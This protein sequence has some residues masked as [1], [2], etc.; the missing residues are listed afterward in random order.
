MWNLILP[1]TSS[2]NQ[3]LSKDT[4]RY[5]E[6]MNKKSSFFMIPISKCILKNCLRLSNLNQFHSLTH[7]DMEFEIELKDPF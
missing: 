3:N 5:V 7:D 4:G 6:N 1:P 2:R